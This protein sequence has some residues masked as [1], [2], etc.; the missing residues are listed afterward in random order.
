MSSR[1]SVSRIAALLSLALVF[2]ACGGGDDDPTGPGGGTPTENVLA[3]S[4]GG[5]HSCALRT[6]G[7]AFCWGLN[8]SGQLGDG[9]LVN[10]SS[11]V[12]VDTELRFRAISA[13]DTHTC[14]ITDGD[15]AY[16]WGDNVHGQ[17][18]GDADA[19]V[20][21]PPTLVGAVKFET[22]SAG[23]D[24]SCG[25]ATNGSA[26]CWGQAFLGDGPTRT[27]RA[28]PVQVS[29]GP[30]NSISA[31]ANYTC[32]IAA[33]GDAYCWGTNAGGL[34]GI[35]TDVA[36]EDTP[37]LVAGGRSYAAISSGI[38]SSC[39]ISTNDETWCWGANNVGQL[40]IDSTNPS[41]NAPQR[42]AG[43]PHFNTIDVGELHAC[44]TSA[45]VTWCWGR[46]S[47]G[48]L[49]TGDLEQRN[50]PAA[51]SDVAFTSV[52]AFRGHTCGLASD[53]TGWCWGGNAFGQVG[54]GG[55]SS[56]VTTPSAVQLPPEVQEF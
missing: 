36:E 12:M 31:A 34:L 1:F 48:Q 47:L 43:D 28:T 11:P 18:G 35:G 49:G 13:G 3:I 23:Q 52:S 16:C 24:H 21:L 50:A 9:T 45:S 25:I 22:I 7:A 42:V 26:Y 15:D 40:G 53:G 2:A 38:T 33:T 32:A 55:T 37:T 27:R 8:T 41:H 10:R 30:Y 46:N 14:A 6:D 44:A 51:V 4:A 39:A 20:G 54:T 5:S 17:A 29:G 19:E 56:R